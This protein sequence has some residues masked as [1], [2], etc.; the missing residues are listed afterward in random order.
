MKGL[1]VFSMTLVWLVGSILGFSAVP[2]QAAD[3]PIELT[4]THHNPQGSTEDLD[5]QKWARKVEADSKGRIVI[6][7]FAGGVLVNAFETYPS[8][9]KGVA[10]IGAGSRYGIGAPF[11]D[12][13]FSL[14]LVG[15]PSV[16]L[17]TRVV[18]DLMKKYPEWYQKEWGD[19]KVLKMM[20]NAGSYLAT[21]NKLVRVP[22]DMKG[23]ELRAPIRAAIELAKG[24]GAKPVS[25]PLSDFVLGM[26]KG[27]VEG[28]FVGAVSIMTFKLAPP[29]KYLLDYALYASPSWYIV[30]NLKKWNSLPPDLQKVLEDASVW[31]KEETAKTLDGETKTAREWY[32]KQGME[33]ITLT[34]QEK[35]KWEDY[36]MSRYMMLS[37]ELDAKGYPATESVKFGQ[38]RLAFYTRG[39]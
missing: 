3:K 38:E 33:I 8:V 37:K 5:L 19:T 18:E 22:E 1:F 12:E 6:R 2:A 9:A 26:Q 13:L 21:R 39:K 31:G 14:A 23:L 15:T 4:L 29:T 11:T 34:P 10:D 7:I 36:T 24:V 28:G 32:V 20:A 16:A 25:M 35:K 27:T 17:S 30:M